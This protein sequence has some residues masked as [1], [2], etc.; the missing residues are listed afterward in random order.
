MIEKI[1]A[2]SRR[3]RR[4]TLKKN[5]TNVSVTRSADV[6]A[7]NVEHLKAVFREVFTEGRIDFDVF[8]QLLSGETEEREEKYGLN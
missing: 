8:K 3:Q 6:V 5:T 7:E 4:K 1:L 2:D